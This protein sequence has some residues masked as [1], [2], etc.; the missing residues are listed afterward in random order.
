MLSIAISNLSKKPFSLYA[1]MVSRYKSTHLIQVS[2]QSSLD[3]LYSISVSVK[4]I[5]SENGFVV[6]KTFS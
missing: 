6:D 1:R 2:F 4:V 3:L 5:I